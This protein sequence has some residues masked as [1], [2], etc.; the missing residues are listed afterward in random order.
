MRDIV[1]EN[2]TCEKV[3]QKPLYLQGFARA[4]MSNITLK[5]CHFKQAGEASIVTHVNHFTLDNVSINGKIVNTQD[6][7]S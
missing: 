3:L 6:L 5:N 7:D 2:F 1:I 4:P